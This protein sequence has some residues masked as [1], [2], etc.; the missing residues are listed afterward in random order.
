MTLVPESR[1][2]FWF[3]VVALP[4]SVL[5]ALYPAAGPFAVLLIAGWLV[6][7]LADAAVSFG[8]LDGI[9][10]SLP[11]VVRLSKDREGS[12]DVTLKNE[13]KRPLRLRLGLALPW[14]LASPHED[15]TVL[16]PAGAEQSRL[17]WPVTP[18]RRGNYRLRRAYL[19]TA[20][21]L[22][23]WV[24]RANV[25]APCEARVYPNLLSERRT[26]AA[27]FLN[28]GAFGIHAQRQVGK[29]RDFEKLREYIPGDGY[30]EIHWKATAK[31]GHPVTKIFQIERTQ[32]V[33]VVIDASRLSA[34][35]PV[36]SSEM[37][38]A[39]VQPGT[40]NPEPGTATA[41]AEPE[42][43]ILE[44]FITSAL[45]LAQAAEKQGDLFGL[46]TFTD[47]AD[48]FLRAKNGKQHYAACRDALY[49]LEP[50]SI[51]PDFDEISSFIRTRLRRRG[52]L[53][54]L[55]SLDD[56]VL[57]ESFVQNMT[58][59]SGQHLVLVNMIKP[60]GVDPLFTNGDVFHIDDVYRHLGGHLRWHNLRELEKV[61]Q[62]RGVS[63]KLV[64]NEKLAAD[65]VGQYLGVKQRQLL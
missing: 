27:L 51:T 48:T 24:V 52:L 9:S 7:A 15:A 32:E 53:I 8:R 18:L 54:F 4:F 62:R 31:R 44:R 56:P 61:L 64:E 41:N 2:L 21:R 63:F 6:L 12:I 33:Y 14:E 34:R 58:L 36:P 20:S 17:D 40:R 25:L 10:V 11:E 38:R 29:G 45:I 39:R 35:Q 5:G 3:A 60:P 28:R 47:K 49:T 42:T 65:L 59:F 50:R 22:G 30:D 13:F 43:T 57:A 19:E 46:L 16:L 23:F 26:L 37:S 55:T 1:L